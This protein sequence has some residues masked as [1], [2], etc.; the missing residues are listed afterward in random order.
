M[1]P[2]KASFQGYLALH[3]SMEQVHAKS[4][5]PSQSK[6]L[7]VKNP[8]KGTWLKS[9]GLVTMIVEVLSL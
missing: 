1:G 2:W 7:K 3:V 5:P 8:V 4:W 9:K 6:L